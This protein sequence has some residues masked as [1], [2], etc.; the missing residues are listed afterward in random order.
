MTR[1][2]KPLSEEDRILWSLVAR[3]TKPLHGKSAPDAEPVFST[4]PPPA[5]PKPSEIA[6]KGRAPM[7]PYTPPVS[8]PR[9]PTHLDLPTLD[10]LAKGRL[11]IEARVDLHGMTQEEAHALL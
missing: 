6:G 4:P 9:P 8:K 5:P 3:S 11:P 2:P 10:G 7:P 1:A